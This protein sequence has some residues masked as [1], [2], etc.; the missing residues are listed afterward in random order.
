MAKIES[1]EK[2]KAGLQKKVAERRQ[3][4]GDSEQQRA[5][6]RLRKRLKRAQRKIRSRAIRKAHASK[7]Q[8]PSA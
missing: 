6:R 8:K 1:V 2:D 7:K 3:Q 5:F 4:L